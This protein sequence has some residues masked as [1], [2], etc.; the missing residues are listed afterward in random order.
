MAFAR[1]R[2]ERPGECMEALFFRGVKSVVMAVIMAGSAWE[3]TGNVRIA[4]V[5]GLMPFVLGLVNI[6][7]T[8]AYLATAVVFMLAV[9]V[10]VIGEDA[11]IEARGMV[12]EYIDNKRAVRST[13]QTSPSVTLPPKTTTSNN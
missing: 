11:I 6:L 13:K 5:A 9:V 12:Q 7:T 10:Q 4:T 2:D 3:L 8:P 1:N